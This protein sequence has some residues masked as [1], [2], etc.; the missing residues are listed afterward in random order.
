[1]KHLKRVQLVG[2][3]MM[4]GF[5]FGLATRDSKWIVLGLIASVFGFVIAWGTR[6]LRSWYE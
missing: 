5:P 1:M 6:I 2:S 4:F 3:A